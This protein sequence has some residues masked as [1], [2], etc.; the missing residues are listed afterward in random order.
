MTVDR[1]NGH[2]AQIIDFLAGRPFGAT[3]M[4]ITLVVRVPYPQV[5]AELE[6]LEALGLVIKRRASN[7]T[8]WVVG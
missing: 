5:E 3:T 1:R 2:T 6:E 4:E 8:V 7:A